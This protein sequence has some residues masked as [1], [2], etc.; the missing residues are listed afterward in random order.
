MPAVICNQA[1]IDRVIDHETVKSL[2][3]HIQESLL[4]AHW[5]EL[6]GQAT[7]TTD[8][9]LIVLDER[10]TSFI[11]LSEAAMSRFVKDK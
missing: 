10:C 5:S 7:C 2:A 9:D 8:I 11:S 4:V 6:I 3:W 1:G